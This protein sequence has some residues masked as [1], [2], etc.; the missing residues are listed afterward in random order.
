MMAT[1]TTGPD[2]VRDRAAAPSV[3]DQESRYARDIIAVHDRM[4][5]RRLP[6]E[7]AGDPLHVH[8]S[9]DG[10]LT[11]AARDSQLPRRYLLGL[12]GFRLAQYLRL[13]WMS[14]RVAYQDALFHEPLR[15]GTGQEDIH[16][17]S[18][19]MA[20]GRIR[21]YMALAGSRDRR[22][23]PLDA[24]E[25]TRLVA[26]HDHRVDL[27]GPYAARGWTTHHVYETK[28]LLRDQTMPRGP[29]HVRVPWH[30]LMASGRVAMALD[31]SLPRLLLAGDAKDT[32]ALRHL[33][34]LGLR[35]DVVGSTSPWLPDTDLLWPLFA[36]SRPP[37][38]FVGRLGT[39]FGRRMDVIGTFLSRP[40]GSES[41][42]GLVRELSKGTAI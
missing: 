5:Y 42:G 18:L 31:R 38:P 10:L 14:E 3:A 40:P 7:I 24:P 9:G 41:V 23:L 26:E 8:E 11:V 19:C 29:E 30:V 27:L 33:R 25:R 20:S 28:R 37:K 15:P 34:L 1:I 35:L 6:D 17:V 4:S 39:D 13:G 32:G 16:V 36:T 12:L 2:P 22:P 21:G